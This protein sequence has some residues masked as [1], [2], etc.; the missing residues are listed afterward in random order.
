VKDPWQVLFEKLSL[1]GL[2]VAL[3]QTMEDGR[4]DVLFSNW[5]EIHLSPS[6]GEV[7][8]KRGERWKL[9]CNLFDPECVTVLQRELL[10]A[11]KKPPPRTHIHRT[12]MKTL[13]RGK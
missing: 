4:V 5:Y 13:L 1:K 2:R 11:G 7:Y 6:S 12:L 8:V 10:K 9:L 3:V